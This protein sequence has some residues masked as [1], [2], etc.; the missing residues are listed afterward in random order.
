MPGVSQPAKRQK[1]GLE[2]AQS[3]QVED[4]FAEV[5]AKIRAQRSASGKQEFF[6]S[7]YVHSA[8]IHH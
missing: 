1:I 3:D 8:L 5:I 4:E 7:R 6:A 2:K